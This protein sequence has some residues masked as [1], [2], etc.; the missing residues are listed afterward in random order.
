MIKKYTYKVEVTKKS[1]E[2]EIF[3]ERGNTTTQAIAP[4]KKMLR[5]LCPQAKFKATKLSSNFEGDML[6]KKKYENKEG[7]AQIERIKK[8]WNCTR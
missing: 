7:K 4:I 1:G 8:T 6:I 3:V 2:K 5:N